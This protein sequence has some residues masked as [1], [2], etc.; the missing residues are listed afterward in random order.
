VVE[1][2]DAV[3]EHQRVVIGQRRDAGA[4][5]DVARAFG[6]RRDEE[7]GARDQFEAGRMMLADPGFVVTELVHPLD[8]FDIAFEREG[9]I[10]I[11]R[12]EG[13]DEGAEA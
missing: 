8:E 10:F 13:R 9:R 12:M 7:L 4:E 11:E 3:G 5:F 2:V 6:D 1:L